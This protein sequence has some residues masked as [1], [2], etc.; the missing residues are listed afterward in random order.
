MDVSQGEA[1]GWT[2]WLS[3]LRAMPRVCP[4]DGLLCAERWLLLGLGRGSRDSRWI[5]GRGSKGLEKML[6][7]K[8]KEGRGNGQSVRGKG[9]YAMK[10]GSEENGKQTTYVVKALSIPCT[11]VSFLRDGG[12][13]C[14]KGG[15]GGRRGDDVLRAA[16]AVSKADDERG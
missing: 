2:V 12:L 6:P 3:L 10:L 5:G 9:T 15:R 7:E 16:G 14:A 11:W 13:G 8:K 1:N 4:A